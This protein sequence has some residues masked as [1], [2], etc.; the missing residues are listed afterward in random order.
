MKERWKHIA[1]TKEVKTELNSFKEPEQ[2]WNDF[3]KE[4]IGVLNKYTKEGTK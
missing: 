3:F 4:V 1:I 2:S